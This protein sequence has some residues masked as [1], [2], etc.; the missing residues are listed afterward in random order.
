M[1][2][3]TGGWALMV[4]PQQNLIAAF[5]GWDILNEERHNAAGASAARRREDS[6][7][8]WNYASKIA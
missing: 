2:A 4:F 8:S 6:R 3:G 7:V 1:A 5:T